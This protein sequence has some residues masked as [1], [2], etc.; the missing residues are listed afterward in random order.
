VSRVLAGMYQMKGAQHQLELARLLGEGVDMEEESLNPS[1]TFRG[2]SAL[3]SWLISETETDYYQRDLRSRVCLA[4]NLCSITRQPYVESLIRG[5]LGSYAIDSTVCGISDRRGRTLLQSVLRHL[6]E[7]YYTSP[8]EYNSLVRDKFGVNC[9]RSQ[10]HS[11]TSVLQSL[12]NF[13]SE[14]VVAG[15]DL[16][17]L[18]SIP[19]KKMRPAQE[20]FRTPL[21]SVIDGFQHSHDINCQDINDS[22]SM[23]RD[24]NSFIETD[25]EKVL[26]TVVLWLRVLE[27]AG[28]DLEQYGQ[29]EKLIYQKGLA[30]NIYWFT[31]VQKETGADTKE[32]IR[33]YVMYSFTFIYG[34]TA[35]DW[36]FWLIEQMDDSFWEFW[37]MVDHPE[38]AMPGY[39]DERFDE[40]ED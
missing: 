39:W 23:W 21:K 36:K 40:M 34:P 4:T 10:N 35:A 19:S 8:Q 20:Y 13:A 24:A 16:H 18:E 31:L 25:P 17:A 9:F 3:L 11:K 29:K 22:F 33:R 30:E 14:L 1:Q 28:I 38:R 7:Q 2:D 32:P 5:L 37:D 12:L 15:S 27:S 6:G 26:V